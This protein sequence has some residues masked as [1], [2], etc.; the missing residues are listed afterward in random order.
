MHGVAAALSCGLGG[1]APDANWQRALAACMADISLACSPVRVH[2]LSTTLARLRLPLFLL[3][4]LLLLPR[5]VRSSCRLQNRASIPPYVALLATKPSLSLIYYL[6]ILLQ[7]RR[8][9]L[10]ARFFARALTAASSEHL[11]PV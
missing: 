1:K 7:T 2:I 3:H 10:Y 8:E 6:V 11:S 5:D 4:P 9:T